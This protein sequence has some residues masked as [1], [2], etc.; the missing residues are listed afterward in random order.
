MDTRSTQL[1]KGTLDMCLLATI[2]Q[3]GAGTG[4]GG[5]GSGE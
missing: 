1:L 5:T 4:P 3:R 2:A